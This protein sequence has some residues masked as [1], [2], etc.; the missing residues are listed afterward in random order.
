V[1]EVESKFGADIY[2]TTTKG[3][4]GP[5][6]ALPVFLNEGPLKEFLQAQQDTDGAV[7]GWSFISAEFSDFTKV[8]TGSENYYLNINDVTSYYGPGKT[9]LYSVPENYLS[10]VNPDNYYPSSTQ[11]GFRT[12]KINGF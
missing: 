4:G 11:A 8:T 6:D 2:I 9:L 3:I 12:Q 1:S 5:A 7:L 10:T